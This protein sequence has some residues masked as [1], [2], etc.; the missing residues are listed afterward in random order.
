MLGQKQLE[1]KSW[2]WKRCLGPSTVRVAVAMLILAL[3]T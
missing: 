1:K 2:L 3:L